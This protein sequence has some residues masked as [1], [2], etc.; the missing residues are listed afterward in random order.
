MRASAVVAL[1]VAGLISLSCGGI[2]DPSK[3]TVDTFSGTLT[4]GGPP[5]THQFSASKTGEIAVKV[6][7]LSPVSNT[8]VGLIW[9]QTQ[10]D[11]NCFG[12]TL[13]LGQTVG[14]VNLTAIS[15]AIASGRYCLIVYDAVGFTASENYT[16]T[17]SHP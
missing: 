14:Q 17:V 7:A 2:T 12:N 9:L 15:N 4:V 6:T 16:V 3:N 11:G 10:S 5:G 13:T 8:Y 1:A